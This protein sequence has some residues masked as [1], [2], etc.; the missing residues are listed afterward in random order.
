MDT[1]PGHPERPA[2]SPTLTRYKV[3]LWLGGAA[4]LA[5]ICRNC[6][7][8]AEKE[9]RHDLG[10]DPF[11]MGLVMSAF[12]LTY[13]LLQIPTGH[14]TDRRGSRHGLPLFAV[15]WSAATALLATASNLWMLL[16]ARLAKGVVVPTEGRLPRMELVA[17]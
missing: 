10:L 3:L 11:Q 8:V 7:G 13:A 6:L 16:G 17:G 9:I 4:T 2:S 5:Y 1:S 14:Y 12:Q 15:V